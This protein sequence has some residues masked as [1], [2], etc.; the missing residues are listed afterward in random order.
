M[1]SCSDEFEEMKVQL[2][3]KGY[4]EK[5]VTISS[6][7]A[8]AL[9]VLY[10]LPFV[11]IS[12]FTYRFWLIGR[13][14]LSEV[15]GPSF[16]IMFLMIIVISTIIHEFLHGIGWAVSS[17]SRNVFRININA[18]MPSCACKTALRRKQYLIGVLTPFIVLG[19]GSVLFILIYPGTVSILTML[20]N[21]VAAGADL[22]IAVNVLK[23]REQDSLIVD[24]PTKAGYI[25]FYK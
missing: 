25:I 16:Y 17:G 14:H 8:M 18:M 6:G 20:V 19:I 1:S 21:F 5:D 2:R 4:Q 15:S 23:E 24:H 22:M 9:G 3:E 11:M 12:G 7:K 10:A 13:A